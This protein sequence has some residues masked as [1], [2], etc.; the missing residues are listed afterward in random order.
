MGWNGRKKLTMNDRVDVN[1][2]FSP[3]SSSGKEMAGGIVM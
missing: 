1:N 2:N 3:S